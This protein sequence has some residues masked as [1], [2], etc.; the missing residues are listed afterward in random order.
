MG[1]PVH[2]GLGCV[3]F[4]MGGGSL[5]GVVIHFFRFCYGLLL[6]VRS[7]GVVHIYILFKIRF[8]CGHLRYLPLLVWSM[9][10]TRTKWPHHKKLRVI[11]AGIYLRL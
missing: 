4:C 9:D 8:R 3:S 6:L 7:I 2:V 1:P 5:F 10:L 11:K